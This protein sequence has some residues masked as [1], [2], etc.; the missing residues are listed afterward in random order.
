[1]TKEAVAPSLE[2]TTREF[3]SLD[4]TAVF[5]SGF[6]RRAFVPFGNQT[7][8]FGPGD[9]QDVSLLHHDRCFA[10]GHDQGATRPWSL[11]Q[12][13]AGPAEGM[14]LGTA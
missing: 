5:G 13:R 11:S 1:M 10:S 8:V 14:A 9:E 4:L 12:H 7:G 6:D 2:P 3:P